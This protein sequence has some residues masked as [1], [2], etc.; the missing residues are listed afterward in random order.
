VA[1]DRALSA[2]GQASLEVPVVAEPL[3]ESAQ[4]PHRAYPSRDRPQP[5]RVVSPPG[6]W[7]PLPA[8]RRT[9]PLASR[10]G[11]HLER[12]RI[13]DRARIRN[14]QALAHERGITGLRPR[15]A[16]PGTNAPAGRKLC[17]SVA[18]IAPITACGAPVRP[19]PSSLPSGPLAWPASRVS[20]SLRR[21]DGHARSS[22]RPGVTVRGISGFVRLNPRYE[23]DCSAD[24]KDGYFAWSGHD[25][26]KSQ[27]M[28]SHKYPRSELNRH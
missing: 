4:Q 15:E 25:L 24:L 18:W 3:T 8:P 17:R 5:R 28:I 26:M 22:S 6:I 14:A 23:N 9:R 19:M 1:S 13:R 16:G 27:S 7:S 21:I 11:W 20:H 10:R 12:V 2:Q